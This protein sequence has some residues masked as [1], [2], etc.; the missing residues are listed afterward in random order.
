MA[1]AD[2]WYA[3]VDTAELELDKGQS[4]FHKVR[5]HQ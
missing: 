4:P 2:V 5:Q 3:D 1:S